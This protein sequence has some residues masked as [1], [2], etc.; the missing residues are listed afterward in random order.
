MLII[1]PYE[2]FLYYLIILLT[3]TMIDNCTSG[4]VRLVGG[5]NDLEGRVEVCYE[6]LWGKVC[7]HSWDNAD[8]NVVCRQ[9]G[10]NP[11]GMYACV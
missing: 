8:A 6:N 9:L 10:Y 11:S 5:G 1:L 3:A 2:F 7:D 4:E